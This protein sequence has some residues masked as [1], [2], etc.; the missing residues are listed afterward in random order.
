MQNELHLDLQ[1][2]QYIREIR[3]RVRDQP[4]V[5]MR[6]SNFAS[7]IASNIK[8][9]HSLHYS[10]RFP[11]NVAMALCSTSIVL[12]RLSAHGCWS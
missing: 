4:G 2:M 5:A 8:A 7:Q 10:T 3:Q 12:L 6:N 9:S 1:S 11:R